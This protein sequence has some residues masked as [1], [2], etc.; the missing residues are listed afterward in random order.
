M[1]V[2]IIPDSQESKFDEEF[3]IIPPA[4]YAM[5]ADTV[6]AGVSSKGTPKISLPLT[7]VGGVYPLDAHGLLDGQVMIDGRR[8]VGPSEWVGK[9]I[10]MNIYLR[11]FFILSRIISGDTSK[12]S[13]GQRKNAEIVAQELTTL[14]FPSASDPDDPF[15]YATYPMTEEAAAEIIA[16]HLTEKYYNE[17]L[18]LRVRTDTYT[19]GDENVPAVNVK[20]IRRYTVQQ[21]YTPRSSRTTTSSRYDGIPY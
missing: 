1:R 7:V 17:P 2:A 12:L 16:E 10:W 3:V 8:V 6:F 4:E 18:Q 14:G 9:K 15:A 19:Y 11:N 20:G 5:T 13:S 21:G